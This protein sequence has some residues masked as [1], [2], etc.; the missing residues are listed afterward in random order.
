MRKLY[1]LLLLVSG[2]QFSFSQHYTHDIGIEIGRYAIQTDFGERDNF[3]STFD[4]GNLSI[5]LSH[6]L[7]FFNR[8]T[9]WNSY[10]RGLNKLA[11]KTQ[12]NLLMTN[13][14]A[15]YGKFSEGNSDLARLLRA[16]KGE[17]SMFNIGVGIEYYLYDLAEFLN[18]YTDLVVNPYFNIGV[19][20]SFYRNR[21]IGNNQ[22]VIDNLPNPLPP[23]KQHLILTY[24]DSDIDG[25][26]LDKIKQVFP[27]KYSLPGALQTGRGTAASLYFGFGSRVKITERMFINLSADWQYFYS[28]AID[29][30]TAPVAENRNNE[31]SFNFSLG[32]VFNLN[33]SEPLRLFSRY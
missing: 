12:V 13:D 4:N 29:G 33:Y 23:N 18:P 5:T 22:E 21:L 14:F 2:F 10:E 15:N 25:A 11:V 24:Y 32:L 17:V 6:Y 19:K 16:M 9:R 7:H 1:F 30:L 28:D 20:Y 26:N 31:T 27:N 8:N 3:K